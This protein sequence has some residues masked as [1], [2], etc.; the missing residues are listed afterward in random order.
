MVVLAEDLVRQLPSRRVQ[1]EPAQSPADDRCPV[2]LEPARP[3]SKQEAPVPGHRLELCGHWHCEM[4]LLLALKRA[5]L[6]L[7]CFEKDCASPWAIADIV[8]AANN[9][10]AL[11][12]DLARRS[13]ECSA[14][15]DTDGRWCPCPTPECHFA[16]DSKADVED[17]GVR[18]LGDVHICP[19]C[20][21]A[22][23]FRCRSL[24][25]YGMSCAAFRASMALEGTS[26]KTRLEGDPGRRAVCPDCGAS[27]ERS[28]TSKGK[29]DACWACRRLFC[30]RCHRR[31]EDDAA[32]ARAHRITE[33]RE[34]SHGDYTGYVV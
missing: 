32:A 11:L 22:V 27:L 33:C 28:A 10:Q 4:C 16:L 19:G 25:H 8:H 6:P 29:V 30:W 3:P 18:V 13:F 17:Q 15:A 1:A 2:C 31:F 12:S 9:D 34:A 7:S 24:Y 23:C 26:D 14:A 20:T 5:T 21:N